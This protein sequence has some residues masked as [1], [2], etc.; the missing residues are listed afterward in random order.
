[1]SWSLKGQT[2]RALDATSRSLDDLNIHSCSM[3]FASLAP[4]AL[5]WEAIAT[6]SAG[7]GTIVPDVG[8]IVELYWN[9][10]RKFRGHV[11]I[12]SLGIQSVGVTVEGP[13]FWLTRTPLT[14][15]QTDATGTSSERPSYVF[16]KQN[17]ATSIAALIDRAIA[18]G[19]PITR[20]QISP[21]YAVPRITLAEM[22]CG[23][24][25]AELM[26][27]CPDAVA[28]FDY[29]TTL[30]TLHIQ[31][32]G[33]S[34]AFT[35]AIPASNV[36]SMKI[37]PRQE[38]R[39]TRVET[40]WVERGPGAGLTKWA[41]DSA[42]TNSVGGRQ[43]VVV[44][45]PEIADFLPKDDR[46]SI[47]VQ[48]VLWSAITD[49]FVKS[50]DSGLASITASVGPVFGG[51]SDYFNRYIWVAGSTQST[52]KLIRTSVPGLRR[53][54]T[55]G[56]AI[57]AATQHLVIS[58]DPLPEW[59]QK[60]YGAIPVSITGTWVAAWR[61]SERGVGTPWNDV[62]MAMQAGAL[63]VNNGL[64][65]SETTGSTKDYAIDWLARPFTVTGYLINQAF[66]ALT[67]IHKPWDYDFET[68]PADLA[69]NLLAAQNWLPWDGPITCI[70]DEV[71]AASNLLGR[72]INVTGS[73]AAAATMKA[74]MKSILYDIKRGRTTYN[75]GA[76]ARTDFGTLVS[77]V[78]REAKD[79][80]VFL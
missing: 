20:G 73:I 7:G 53:N 1:M 79:N 52:K 13:W 70:S 8:Q 59:A 38:L 68:P 30:P 16:R 34:T 4:D 61:D 51:V 2:G 63:T 17:L 3:E 29:S 12:P 39:V 65:N 64:Q 78:R 69:D 33:P 57:P 19:C 56:G 58:S 60:L 26:R 37:A 40:K 48:T 47:R 72:T 49:N 6:N 54:P 50:R 5:T 14:S 10:T 44:S 43:I 18:N 22:D 31:R 35:I 74:P 24:A 75:L 23:T 76:P 21:M 32:R 55:N 25:L 66:A 42:G 41:G 27:W 45:G 62:F 80:I 15:A 46:D 11:T 36:E 28:W 67:T 9:A 71:T 77:R